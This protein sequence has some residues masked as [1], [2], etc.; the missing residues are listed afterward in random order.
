M[1]NEL[2][3]RSGA[4]A[5]ALAALLVLTSAPAV[6][7]EQGAVTPKPTER[8]HEL[9]QL[10]NGIAARCPGDAGIEADAAVLFTEGFE[11]RGVADVVARWTDADNKGGEVLAISSDVSLMSAGRQSLE[12]TATRG[13]NTGG[14]LWKLFDRGADAMHVRFYVKFA[15]DHPYVDKFVRIGALRDA[16]GKPREDRGYRPDGT[17]GFNVSLVPGGSWGRFGPPGAWLMQSYWRQMRSFQGPGGSVFYGNSFAP[18]PA[19]QAPRGQWQCMEFMV[20]ANSAPER[21]DGEQAF[22]IDGKLAGRWGPNTPSGKWLADSFITQESGQLFEGFHWRLRD[23]VKLNN[24]W[25]R[26]DLAAAFEGNRQF[27]PKEGVTAN[28]DAGRVWFDDIVI[29]TEYIGPIFH[30]PTKAGSD[31]RSTDAQ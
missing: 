14:H 6:A 18:S 10:D 13:R 17:R 2:R 23:D 19:Q 11:E 3:T 7:L 28:A 24:F 12:M 31:L 30:A 29:A 25:L 5:L 16:G 4:G 26:Y 27:Q 8:A 9:P 20:K 15:G 1:T 21:H 22:W